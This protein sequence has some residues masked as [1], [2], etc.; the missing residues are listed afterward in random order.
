M[1]EVELGEVFKVWAGSIVAVVV[2]TEA[3]RTSVCVRQ[4]G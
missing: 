3:A 4:L 1:G 2:V